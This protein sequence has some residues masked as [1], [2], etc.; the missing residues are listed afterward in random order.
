MR[1]STFHLSRVLQ[2]LC[3]LSLIGFL[4]ACLTQADWL[5]RKRHYPH[6]EYSS[7][8]VNHYSFNWEMSGDQQILP[9]QAFSTQDE[10]WLHYPEHTTIPAIFEVNDDARTPIDLSLNSQPSSETPLRYHRNPPYIVLKG[11][12]AR[13][14]LRLGHYE[15]SVWHTPR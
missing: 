13:L 7:R 2:R 6:W 3:L 10:V 4:A 1:S 11:H 8:Q 12:P 15:A 9:I 14:R 5:Q